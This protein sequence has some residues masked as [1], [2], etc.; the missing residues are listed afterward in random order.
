M[1]TH[2]SRALRPGQLFVLVGFGVTLALPG[3]AVAQPPAAQPSSDQP[4][5]AAP[6]DPFEHA[7]R[8]FYAASAS[9]DKHIFLPLAKLYHA[10]T[11]GF[12]GVAIHNIITNLSEPVVIANDILQVRLK[13]AARDTARLT[14]NT[15]AGFG[16][17]IDVAD[18]AGI[19]YEANDFGVTLGVWGFKPGPYLFLP[20]FGPSTVR[21]TIGMGVDAVLSPFNY[22]RFPGRTTLNVSSQVVGALDQR[23]AQQGDYDALLSG[24]A[25]P[26]ATLRS[27]YLQSREADVRGDETPEILPPLDDP[28]PAA[29]PAPAPSAAAQPDLRAPAMLAAEDD[30]DRPMMTASPYDRDEAAQLAALD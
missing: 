20:M 9:G 15:L 14:A 6:G 30:P 1:P 8:K 17:I 4:T 5:A 28:A 22:L 7:N 13:R 27:V 26:Y 18:K 2:R 29:G 21:D 16:G 3:L 19:P 10:L 11:P 25:D 23:I 24:A 12:I